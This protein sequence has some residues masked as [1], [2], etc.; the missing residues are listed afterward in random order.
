MLSAQIIE[1][2]SAPGREADAQ[3]LAETQ[4]KLEEAKAKET[5]TLTN[6]V[7][8]FDREQLGRVAEQL[9]AERER[10]QRKADEIQSRI[11]KQDNLMPELCIDD[12][13]NLS[14]S[15]VKDALRR[16]ISW[17]AV[18]SEGIIVLTNWGTYI[19]ATFREIEK[20]VFFSRDTRRVINPPSPSSALRC[21]T[22]LP[23]PYDFLK[24]RRVYMGRRSESLS[25]EEILPGLSQLNDEQLSDVEL[26]IEVVD[27]N[28]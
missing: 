2:R 12:L 6:L 11:G 23:S 28:N 7:G 25:D 3:S 13:A 26:S 1:M 20:S 16:V 21:L 9:R 8:V 10:L 18:G 17:I 19:G 5:E 15:T 4:R 22:W 24:G 14:K 27:L